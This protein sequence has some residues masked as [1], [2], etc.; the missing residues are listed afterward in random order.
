M[1]SS[2]L[3]L[4][5]IAELYNGLY[6]QNRTFTAFGLLIKVAPQLLELLKNPDT[7]ALTSYV[8]KVQL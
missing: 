6:R 7:T 4:A 8:Y 3:S 1:S 5:Y 2:Y